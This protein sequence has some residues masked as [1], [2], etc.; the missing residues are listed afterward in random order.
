[1]SGTAKKTDPKLW[2]KVKK[3]VTKSD[4]GGRPGQWSAR[5]A[6]MATQEYKSRGGGYEGEKSSDNHLKQWTDEDWGTKSGKKSE[7]TGERYLP[8]KARKNLSKEEYQRTTRKKRADTRRGKQYSD[9]PKDVAKKTA[10]HRDT[11][12]AS[13]KSSS[14]S[15]A[16]GRSG[17]EPSKAELYEKAKKQDI[18]GRSKMSKAELMKAVG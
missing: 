11:G 14:R 4:K 8:K 16:R 2:E 9:Q 3:D 6:Q 12:H 10:R 1:M 18:A 15:S 7:D 17:G 13:S 5:K